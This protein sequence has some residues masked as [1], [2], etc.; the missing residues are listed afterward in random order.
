MCLFFW[1]FFS[2]SGTPSKGFRIWYSTA[3]PPTRISTARCATCSQRG[4]K[5]RKQVG[6][7]WPCTLALTA[8]NW[9]PSLVPSE[10]DKCCTPARAF[11]SLLQEGKINPSEW[12]G[13]WKLFEL[14]SGT[15][16]HARCNS[17]WCVI[18]HRS[19]K[20]SWNIVSVVWVVSVIAARWCYVS[21]TEVSKM[22]K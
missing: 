5:G 13:Q 16:S 7:A 14:L 8:T 20:T 18:S 11:T 19:P 12:A 15:W 2:C 21:F 6:R 4:L 3:F 22:S 9:L 10:P 1:G 17:W